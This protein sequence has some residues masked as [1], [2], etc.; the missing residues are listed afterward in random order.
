MPNRIPSYRLHKPSGRAGVTINGND[1]YLGTHGSPESKEAYDR[2]IGQW[3][4]TRSTQRNTAAPT[5]DALTVSEPILAYMH[6]A[7]GYYCKNGKPTP[8]LEA[9]KQSFRLLRTLY[10]RTHASEFR[11][12]DRYT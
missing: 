10:A 6:H 3:L 2:L 5:T 11:R 8:E 9:C 12:S 4:L 7:T 1:V